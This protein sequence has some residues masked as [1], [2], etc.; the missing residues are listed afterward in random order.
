MKST[1]Q[2][3]AER[4]FTLAEIL[5]ATAV[6]T[7]ILVAGLLIYDRSNKVF[8]QGVESA[9]LQQSTRVGFDKIVADL[10]MAGFDYDRDGVPQLEDQYQQP[11]EQIEYAGKTAIVMRGN[12]DFT[13]DAAT[14]HGREKAYEPTTGEF[15]IV[16]T[17]NDEIVTYALKS[18]DVSKNT[19]SFKF[20]ADVAK[21]R[22]SYPGGSDETEVTV[23]G[24]DLT[25]ANPPYTLYRFTLKEDGTL[26]AG[27]P[28]A[29]NVRSLNFKYYTDLNGATLLFKA[30]ANDLPQGA[31][32]GDGQYRP[33]SVGTTP[34][35][36]D[37]DKRATIA[38][39]K[40][41]LVG[42]NTTSDATY[43]NTAETST[44]AGLKSF[45]QYA[46]SSLIVPRNL[47][48]SGTAEVDTKAP[49]PASLT[50]I[51]TGHCAATV[52]NWSASTSGTV[53]KYEV[54]WDTDP[55]GAFNNTV[56][57]ATSLSAPV[58]SLSPGTVHYFKVLAINDH[59]RTW[60]T[61]TLSADPVNRT[62][63]S[64]PSGGT[65]SINTTANSIVINWT[66]PAS[67]EPPLNTLSCVPS[68]TQAASSIPAYEGLFYRIWR[69]TTPNFNPSAGEGVVVLGNSNPT[70]QPT[71]APGASVT[72]TDSAV[73]SQAVAGAPAN[74]ID[75][76][77][78][79]Q[80]LDRC[81]T[82]SSYNVPNDVLTASSTI[83]PAL[84]DPA[85]PGRAQS[86]VAPVTPSLLAIDTATSNCSPAITVPNPFGL[87]TI[88][89][90]W[91]AVKGDVSGASIGVDTYSVRRYRK[92]RSDLVGAFV[93]DP[94]APASLGVT[95]ATTNAAFSSGTVTFTDTAADH[96]ALL[97]GWRYQYFVY[98]KQCSIT[99]GASPAAVF[100]SPCA[101]T[102]STVTPGGASG[103]TGLTVPTAWVM[104]AGDTVTVAPPMGITLSRVTFDLFAL[105]GS[106]I[107]SVTVGSAPFTYSWSDR[108]DLQVYRLSISITNTANCTE[109]VTRYI[110]DEAPPTCN[111]QAGLG[112]LLYVRNNNFV[113]MTLSNL[114]ATSLTIN[115]IR[116]DWNKS[117]TPQASQANITRIEYPPA[118]GIAPK[119]DATSSNAVPQTRTPPAGIATV[120]GLAPNYQIKVFFGGW[121]ASRG[122]LQNNPIRNFCVTYTQGGATLSCRIYPS[123]DTT[124]NPSTC[125]F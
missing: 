117:V 91:P 83:Y 125:G 34:N 98:A 94:T 24:V 22:A 122:N 99:G 40:V 31:I 45:R 121:P 20:W 3:N 52:V 54:R 48:L 104:N 49:G 26:D 23:S 74:C 113:T 14:D 97:Q 32:G 107:D 27:V 78:R 35:Y 28:V 102:G 71:S 72:W 70:S 29:D 81:S 89:M 18:A 39:V 17:G 84:S 65:A 79:I 21:P 124:N 115:S 53:L 33:S 16:T 95:G 64:P 90:S 1:I 58:P 15:P 87:C 120:G 55:N 42:M 110:Q 7:L 10:R 36:P 119:V 59:G 68:G 37:R 8:K 12:L 44:V 93:I 66:A 62:K 6:F 50:S 86:A 19:D 60:S 2:R 57:A 111:L 51:C 106:Q 63:P 109:Q 47:G 101:L 69:G 43:T 73:S 96:D 41:D 100:P 114:S 46:L 56:D 118:V 123:A 13:T 88:N 4:G 38:S 75:Y 76:Y 85:I 105:N 67:N 116:I 61:N 108:T 80:A 5:V 92:L 112:T 77:Y 25:N 9:E 103:G 11:D 82:N 30:A